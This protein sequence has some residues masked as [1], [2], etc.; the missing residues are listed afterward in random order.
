MVSRIKSFFCE[1]MAFEIRKM[2]EIQTAEFVFMPQEVS[3]GAKL[4]NLIVS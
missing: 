2:L 4:S 3:H 1:D